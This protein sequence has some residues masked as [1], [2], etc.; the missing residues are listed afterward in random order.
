MIQML[1]SLFQWLALRFKELALYLDTMRECYEA[2]VIYNFM[3]FLLAYLRLQYPDLEGHLASKPA[4]GH[5]MPFCC[6][7]K[8]TMGSF[9]F[10]STPTTPLHPQPSLFWLIVAMP[11]LQP[12]FPVAP[13]HR[14]VAGASV[15]GRPKCHPS[16]S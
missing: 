1:G 15:P 9:R 4:V 3:A 16:W 14:R 13:P 8:W 11:L 6:L 2:Y 10:S 5:F 12:P 7:P